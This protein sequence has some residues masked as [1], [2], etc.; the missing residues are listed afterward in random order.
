[1]EH[2]MYGFIYDYVRHRGTC[3]VLSR[4]DELGYDDLERIE[5]RMLE[6]NDIPALLPLEIEEIDLQVRLRYD[7]TGK[8]MLSQWM[9]TGKLALHEYYRFL[10]KCAGAIDDSKAYMLREDGYWLHEDFLFVAGDSPEAPELLYV[11][12]RLGDAVPPVREQFRELALRLSACID[13]I[14]GSGFS[15]LLSALH[16]QA[17]EFRDIRRL[18]GSFLHPEPDGTENSEDRCR[19]DVETFAVGGMKQIGDDG[20]GLT[21]ND[22]SMAVN[23]GAVRTTNEQKAAAKSGIG[24]T[25]NELKAAAKSGTRRTANEPKPAATTEPDARKP[26]PAWITAGDERTARRAERA[27]RESLP[28]GPEELGETPE[29]QNVGVAGNADEPATI[30][31]GRRRA[32]IG[33]AGAA[34]LLLLWSFYP[35]GAHEGLLSVWTGVTLLALDALFVSV[36]LVPHWTG[37]GKLR[38]LAKSYR[39]ME[40]RDATGLTGYLPASEKAAGKPT[41]SHNEETIEERLPHPS[42]NPPG[43]ASAHRPAVSPKPRDRLLWQGRPGAAAAVTEPLRAIRAADATVLLRTS[44]ETHD[45]EDTEGPD[46][47]DGVDVE[48]Y[49][50]L[51]AQKSGAAERIPLRAERFLIGRDAGAVDFIEETAGVSKVHLELFRQGAEF[52]AKDL[53]SRN[54]TLWNKEPMVPYKW[55]PLKD[56]DTLQI[57]NTRFVFVANGWNEPLQA[58]PN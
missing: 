55:Y 9:K 25:T 29:P 2:S 18:L 12:V 6:A 37:K 8:R 19:T 22:L 30:P 26:L 45:M 16:R 56:G 58:E 42:K 54:G 10:L 23:G 24:W 7:I 36:T 17:F 50:E 27:G 44:A 13:K 34:G 33:G 11:P 53:G 20:S 31:T 49:P 3:L 47:P 51:E 46:E 14:E 52:Y 15:R 40:E 39:E 48:R 1:M 32:L 41:L 28:A 35:Q 4:A 43:E 21:V 38:S 5:L 57:V